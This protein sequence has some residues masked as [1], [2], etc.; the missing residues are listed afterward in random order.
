LTRPAE[1]RRIPLFEGATGAHLA[2]TPG[3]DGAL[4][5]APVRVGAYIDGF[6]VYH[7]GAELSGAHPGWK[8]LDFRALAQTLANDEWPG[9][10]HTIERVVYCTASVKPTA[11]DPDLPKRQQ[12]FINALRKSGSV[13]WVEYGTF[14]DKV[15]TRPLAL[16]DKK[17]RPVLVRPQVP[18][19]VKDGSDNRVSDAVFMVTVADREEKGSDV[20][21]GTHL[22]L[23]AL[24]SPPNIDA[25]IV[26]SN[27][28]DLKLPV[29]SVRQLMPLGIV[30]PGRGFTAGALQ[31]DPTKCV[32]G[33]WERQLT[34]A[35]FTAHQLPDPV[36]G[37]AKPAGW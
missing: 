28:S 13:D 22:L 36:D 33:Q 25:A 2:R 32:P 16:R 23:D 35:D 6:N 20:N 4:R 26:I 24:T 5:S 10:T 27:D 30:N 7:G 3:H 18:V 19:L 12:I 9:D 21:V 37:Y 29:A 34:Y 14:L 1:P 11:M 17:G 31:H 8:W 15:K